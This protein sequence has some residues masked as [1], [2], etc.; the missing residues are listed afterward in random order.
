[1]A[2]PPL[3]SKPPPLQLPC[4]PLSPVSAMP[5][6]PAPQSPTASLVSLEPPHRRRAPLPR[7]HPRHVLPLDVLASVS[8]EQRI[9]LTVN[10]KK[11]PNPST[12][13]DAPVA[14][15][16]TFSVAGLPGSP[17]ASPPISPIPLATPFAEPPKKKSKVATD[18]PNGVSDAKPA[19]PVRSFACA[20]CP[21]TF[22]QKFNLNKHERSVHQH[23]RPFE[24]QTCHARFQQKSHRTMHHL[25]VHE[26][27][28]Q[29]ACDLCGASFSWRGVLKKHRKSIHHRDD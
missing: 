7:Q 12:P 8:A 27:L 22:S 6:L 23:L 11:R 25:A 16:L 19:R 4:L 13:S 26:K 2:T 29:F 20:Q 15:G 3:R 24:C 10:T 14:K 1:M 17:V 18:S 5:Q 9:R 28:R 21:S